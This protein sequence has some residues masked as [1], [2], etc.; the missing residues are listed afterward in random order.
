MPG[1]SCLIDMKQ[2]LID[3]SLT[4]KNW[5]CYGYIVCQHIAFYSSPL[6]IGVFQS[7]HR[8]FTVMYWR[9]V[10]KSCGL[11][12]TPNY[13]AD[14]TNIVKLFIKYHASRI[15]IYRSIVV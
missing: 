1:D 5:R 3:Y 11:T 7:I 15:P 4:T 10:H 6:I 2:L 9:V 12:I 14:P 13:S 8:L